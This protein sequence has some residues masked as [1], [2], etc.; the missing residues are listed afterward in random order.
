MKFK[1]DL[2]NEII[3]GNVDKKEEGIL[4]RTL[5]RNILKIFDN[6]IPKKFLIFPQNPEVY[7]LSHC[8]CIEVP[9]FGNNDYLIIL[10][11]LEESLMKEFVFDIHYFNGKTTFIVKKNKNRNLYI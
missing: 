8:V 3:S 11:Y 1:T 4:L 5:R 6:T 7:V 10:K 9:S 2:I